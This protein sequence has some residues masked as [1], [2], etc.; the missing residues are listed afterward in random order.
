MVMIDDNNE[1][2]M[3]TGWISCIRVRIFVY[4]DEGRLVRMVYWI[5]V[6]L[7]VMIPVC[8]GCGTATVNGI[9]KRR[10]KDGQCVY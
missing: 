9:I 8:H 1:Q 5:P 6:C 2:P 3:I 7:D 4:P 10:L